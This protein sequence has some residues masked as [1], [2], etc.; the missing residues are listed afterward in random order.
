MTPSNLKKPTPP[1]DGASPIHVQ[2]MATPGLGSRDHAPS[3]LSAVERA[4][5]SLG[6]LLACGSVTFAGYML[7][8]GGGDQRLHGLAH[9]GLFAMPRSLGAARGNTAGEPVALASKT[10]AVDM[11]PTGAIAKAPSDSGDAR[12]GRYVIAGVSGQRAWLGNG[13]GFFLFGVGDYVPGLGRVLAI[14]GED[15]RWRV[16][17]TG[18]AIENTKGAAKNGENQARSPVFSRSMIFDG[19]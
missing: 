14:D 17:T 5:A 6:V 12:G 2:P 18:G 3:T 7:G 11:M 15:G 16:L 19:R 13:N 8:G 4:L 9:L 1:R 10:E